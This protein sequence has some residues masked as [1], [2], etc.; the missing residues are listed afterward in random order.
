MFRTTSPSGCFSGKP[1][2][3]HYFVLFLLGLV[4]AASLAGAQEVDQKRGIDSRVD[5]QALKS[6]G[7]WDDRN[8]NL[9][10]TDLEVLSPNEADLSEP[11]PAFFRVEMRKAWPE[12]MRT[13]PA[14]Y[15][16]SA[17]Q[18][19][20]GMYGGYLVDGQLYQ[21]VERTKAGRF[22]VV[23]QEGI[24]PKAFRE[25]QEKFLSGEVRV[26]SPVGA[27]ESAIKIHPSNTDLVI[28]GS[29]GPG[30][31]QKMHYSTDGG[32]T[33]NSSAPLPLGGTCCDPTVEWS[34]DGS[35]SYTATLGNCS[36]SG[37][38]IWFYRSDD[39]GMTWDDLTDDTPG[40][41]R[42]ELTFS[43][44]DKEFLHVDIHPSSPHVDNLYL[45][46]HNSNIMQF[47]VSSDF[48]NNWTTT[49]FSSATNQRGIGS[50]ITTDAAGNVYYFWPAFVSQKIW[51]RKSTNGGGSFGPLV[52]VA[53]TNA[54]F[55]FP[56]PSMEARQVFVYVSADTDRTGGTYDGSVYA[57]WS[58]S[59]GPTSGI[60]SANHARIVVAYSRDGGATWNYSTPHETAD[61]LTVDRYH[62]WLSVGPD[63]T[64]HVIFYDTRRD[65]TRT[66]VD[67]FYSFSTDGAVTF[68]TPQRLTA[69][70]SPN[71]VNS[72][73]F[74][75]YNGLDVI[76]ND[77]IAI[78]TDNRNESG[79]SGDSVD[80]YASGQ[81]MGP[82]CGNGII[83]PPEECDGTNLG[84]AT[85]TS[86]GFAAGPLACDAL[87][88]QFDTSSCITCI[89]DVMGG[90]TSCKPPEV[91]SDYVDRAC[92]AQGLYTHGFKVRDSCG[93]GN[94]RFA[95][96][97]CCDAPPSCRRVTLGG[98]T[99]CKDS[100]TW[101]KYA[102]DTC[103]QG[104]YTLLHFSLNTP[105]GTGTTPEYRFTDFA[106][107]KTY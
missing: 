11:I 64:V 84:G 31:G 19:F 56:V 25:M 73:E 32:A 71:I 69:E 62:Q 21:G 22:E 98:P 13:G 89:D 29:N 47:A 66:S 35:L 43:G 96:Y 82:T 79:G 49:S 30:F 104:G 68:S 40:D 7:P 59:T 37:C 57:A 10:A 39:G 48:G 24:T 41:P 36:F 80:V 44:S 8:Y 23:M 27:A 42:R 70:Q 53:D 18:I 76:M 45:T 90:P 102:N 78:Y 16:R 75:D 14:Q 52:D 12:L 85:C 54:S 92:R 99:S 17:L 86:L 88:C 77:L 9:T 3:R 103:D 60:P 106:C 2:P 26:T 5:Y 67:V 38:A 83:E 55:I 72:F 20:F 58:D 4:L 81:S 105:C 93:G 33:W 91:W 74:G 61:A 95:H 6:F 65:P 34:S 100:A 51:M 15:P 87:T 28:A 107:C 94:Y 63:G 101:F 50:D 1:T 97:R 46:W